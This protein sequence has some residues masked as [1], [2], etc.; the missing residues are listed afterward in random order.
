MLV[1]LQLLIKEIC[2]PVIPIN[3]LSIKVFVDLSAESTD[4]VAV[5]RSEQ[6]DVIRT[7]RSGVKETVQKVDGGFGRILA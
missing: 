4:V 7:N 2:F 5:N 3:A 6:R 1:S